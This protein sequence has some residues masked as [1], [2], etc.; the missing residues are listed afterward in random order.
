[1][2]VERIGIR[3]KSGESDRY[4]EPEVPVMAL[5]DADDNPSAF[6]QITFQCWRA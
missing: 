5:L 6:D 1:V 2:K 3:P 4:D